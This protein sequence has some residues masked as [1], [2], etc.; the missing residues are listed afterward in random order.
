MWCQE[1]LESRSGLSCPVNE[2]LECAGVL[3][4]RPG[5]LCAQSSRP[6]T[7]YTEEFVRKQNV[8][9]AP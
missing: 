4:G 1:D 8:T 2:G 5:R 7:G 9:D 3:T 6:H